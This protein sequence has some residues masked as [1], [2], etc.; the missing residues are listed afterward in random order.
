MD[1]KHS[2][3]I[4][5]NI[6]AG[7]EKGLKFFTV[8]LE[9]KVIEEKKAM[10]GRSENLKNIYGIAFSNQDETVAG[11]DDGKVYF[12]RQDKVEEKSF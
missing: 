3:N 4:V 9:E 1:Y 12:F 10:M 11:G 6:V 8:K 2:D 7:V 5:L